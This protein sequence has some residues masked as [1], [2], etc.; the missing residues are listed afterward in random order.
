ME[1]VAE[2]LGVAL[3]NLSHQGL[4]SYLTL[5]GVVIGIAAIVTLVSLGEGLNNAVEEQ[6][7]QLG[8]NTLF[9]A[10]GGTSFTGAQEQTS[11]VKTLRE[12]EIDDIRALPEVSEV[13]APLSSS[14][15]LSF[16]RESASAIVIGFDPNEIKNIEDTGFMEIQEGRNIVQNDGFSIVLGNTVAVELFDRDVRVHDHVKLDGKTFKVVGITKPT[17][18]A[19][20][21]GPN[22][23][24]TVF[25]PEKAFRQL[26]ADSA[27]AFLLVKTH[28]KEQ[29]SGAK[30]KIERIFERAYGRDQKEF[31]VVTSEQ[32]LEQISQVLGI[33]Q[34]FLAGIASISLLVGGIGIMNTMVM[35]VLERTTEIGVMKAIGATNS[36]VMS[37]FLLE[38][39]LIGLVGGILGVVLGYALAFAVGIAGQAGGFAL[40]VSLNPSLIVGALL[41]SM[42]V[43]MISGALPA[44]SAARLDPV[45]ALRG[46]Q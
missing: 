42:I 36:L 1:D 15:T 29:V 6:F 33:I 21:G 41:F 10:P 40:S 39:G 8:S 19:F 13:I 35:A 24:N 12:T 28:T 7:E 17:S 14:A 32:I 4:R 23:N 26:Y 43:G 27:P 38:A 25:I 46:G 20:G 9:V 3:N 31:G 11:N 44:R 45:E 34:L 30:K 5:L 22:T 16:G 18:Q 37:I 2:L